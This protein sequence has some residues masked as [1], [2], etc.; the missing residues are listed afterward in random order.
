MVER[1]NMTIMEHARS[2]RL[3]VGLPLNMWEK[4]VNKFFYLINRSPSTPLG[5]GIP[6]ES[7]DW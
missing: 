1:M 4:A 6:R 7:M 3:H 2:M 5:C